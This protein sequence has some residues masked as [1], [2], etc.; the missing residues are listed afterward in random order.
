VKRVL[1]ICLVLASLLLAGCQSASSPRSDFPLEKVVLG[2][3]MHLTSG[4]IIPGSVLVIGGNNVVDAGAVIQGDYYQLGGSVDFNGELTGDLQLIGAAANILPRAIIRGDL[5]R[6]SSTADIQAG[7]VIGGTNTISEV[8]QPETLPFTLPTLEP[9]KPLEPLK[10]L[11]PAKSPE[12]L[13]PVL[14]AIKVT[15]SI[16]AAILQSLLAMIIAFFFS[17]RITRAAERSSKRTMSTL[18]IGFLG[19]LAAPFIIVLTILTIIGIPLA[20]VEV[21]LLAAAVIFGYIAMGTQIGMRL[22]AA[23]RTRWHPAIHAGVGTFLLSLG[24]AA[25][26]SLGAAGIIL[27]TLT[28]F[29]GFGVT[30]RSRFGR[31]GL[32]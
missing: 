5:I 21:V 18:L 3:E 4:D 25:L 14:P 8:T 22:S 32:A 26:S 19:A 20:V 1:I 27:I 9:L 17:D 13:K 7:A 24:L 23:F 2:G 28:G 12:L 31:R 29:L 11:Q 6:N 16:F 10:T 30:I 15:G